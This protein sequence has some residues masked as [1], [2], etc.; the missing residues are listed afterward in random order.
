MPPDDVVEFIRQL[1]A[2]S[3]A[4]WRIAADRWSRLEPTSFDKADR[5]ALFAMQQHDMGDEALD[6]ETE[7]GRIVNSMRF[8]ARDG[9]SVRHGEL[10][11]MRGAALTAGFGYLARAEIDDDEFSLLTSPF[12]GLLGSAA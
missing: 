2:L 4:E 10:E 12:V 9:A 1:S 7:I 5:S 11:S 3:L 8:F 6:L